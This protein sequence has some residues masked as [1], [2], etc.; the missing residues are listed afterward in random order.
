[1]DIPI[2]S[3]KK[4]IDGILERIKSN[5]NSYQDEAKTWLY[6]V[7]SGNDL[8]GYDFY[9]EAKNIFLRSETSQRQIKVKFA[10]E[11]ER[12]SLPNIIIRLSS[13]DKKG[14]NSIGYGVSEDGFIDVGGGNIVNTVSRGFGQSIE[15]VFTSPSMMETTLIYE[16][17]YAAI[18]ANIN[19]FNY[20][21]N[22]LEI[23]GRDL[24]PVN[25]DSFIL[26]AKSIVL[27]GDFIREVPE[28]TTI[29]NTITDLNFQETLILQ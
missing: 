15:L 14:V 3:V 25:Q 16:T 27:S 8:D 23:K 11:K 19:S 1:M 21:Y 26:Y 22:N 2:L 24:P 20:V 29:D 9:K 17:M 6:L 10:F 5:Y 13:D 12:M 7:L 4:M 28:M 18:E